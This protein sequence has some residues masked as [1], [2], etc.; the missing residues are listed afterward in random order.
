MS[1][2]IDKH[3]GGTQLA[4][5]AADRPDLVPGY[6]L[7]PTRRRF[8]ELALRAIDRAGK[9]GVLRTQ[10]RIVH[11]AAARV[12]GEPI[13]HVVGADFLYDE[14]SPGMLASGVLLK[15]IDEAIATMRTRG[16]DGELEARVCALVLLI[17]QIP[18][19]S[20]AGVTG[21]RATT[22]FLADVL[23]EDLA[24]DGARLRRRVPQVLRT[25]CFQPS[26]ARTPTSRHRRKYW[27]VD[28][29]IL[30][31]GHA[32]VAFTPHAVDD[33]RL[34]A[35]S[36]GIDTR[37]RENMRKI[38]KNGQRSRRLPLAL[39]VLVPLGAGIVALAGPVSAHVSGDIGSAYGYQLKVNL[40]NGSINTRG[41]GQVTCTGTDPATRQP[42]PAGCVPS[43]E[44]DAA[45]SPLVTLPSGGSTTLSQSKGSTS[46][47]VGPAEF[48][49]S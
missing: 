36:G 8:W 48:F 3:L 7:L 23:V 42:I 22:G 33:G 24:N 35:G 4:P 40:F 13:G 41:V 14:Q 2:E 43:A 25:T 26:S 5:R 28:R 21:L 38:I 30:G 12:A 1:G 44:A 45:A 29:C 47:V 46:A 16:P 17:S 9:T 39:A 27:S 15:E 37:D 49:S 32:T 19:D 34:L 10:P 31:A 18:R 20:F 11:E 6:P